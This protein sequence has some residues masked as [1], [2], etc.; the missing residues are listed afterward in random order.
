MVI[1]ALIQLLQKS[2][3]LSHLTTCC[4]QLPLDD[5]CLSLKTKSKHLKEDTALAARVLALPCLLLIVCK[6]CLHAH[7]GDH[8]AA[9]LRPSPP[10]MGIHKS[11]SSPVSWCT[12]K[13]RLKSS[14]L[15][16]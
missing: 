13:V 2:A 15:E 12:I 3:H 16:L 1:L 14:K 8:K 5:A 9:R 4:D 7:C 10:C 11:K 6:A